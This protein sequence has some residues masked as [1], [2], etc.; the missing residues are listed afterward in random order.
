LTEVKNVLV[1]LHIF[2]E[3]QKMPGYSMTAKLLTR[4]KQ[5]ELSQVI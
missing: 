1:I 2:T 3:T 4:R 5:L